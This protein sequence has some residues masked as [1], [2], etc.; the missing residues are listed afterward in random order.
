[1]EFAYDSQSMSFVLFFIVVESCES[2]CHSHR[3]CEHHLAKMLVISEVVLDT[4]LG[5]W[6]EGIS[7]GKFCSVRIYQGRWVISWSLL[8]HPPCCGAKE[9]HQ[10]VWVLQGEGLVGGTQAFRHPPSVFPSSFLSSSGTH[11]SL[12]CPCSQTFGG[13]PQLL[14]GGGKRRG[15][16]QKEALHRKPVAGRQASRCWQEPPKGGVFCPVPGGLG[17]EPGSPAEARGCP[18][19]D[20]NATFL[21]LLGWNKILKS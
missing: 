1:M 3:K 6:W 18:F 20:E 12:T 2:C 9:I 17:L 13:N 4:P 19:R 16:R 10:G 14:S 21:P 11:K 7:E 15:P 8:I 5:P